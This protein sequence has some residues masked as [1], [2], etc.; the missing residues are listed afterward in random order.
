VRRAQASVA[1]AGAD[2]TLAD[3]AAA[4]AVDRDALHHAE[5][6]AVH[7]RRRHAAAEQ[8]LDSAPRR[9][10]RS[11]RRD[12]DIAQQQLDRA[13]DYLERTRQRTSPAVE[14]HTHAVA[15][16]RHAHDEFRNC[17]T[18][19]LLDSMAPSV[20]EQRLHVQAL[21]NWK[22]WAQ[23]HD[24]P[25]ASLH[26]TFAGLARQPGVQRHLAAALRNDLPAPP[27]DR[28][29]DVADRSGVHVTRHDFGIEL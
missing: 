9:Q 3:V 13:E 25:D 14:R 5:A 7:A 20:G 29:P 12:V 17:D 1:A 4:T 15:N 10:R 2:S 27:A 22:R 16:Q 8:R 21:T 23:G 19:D 18:V 26:T 24:L 11:L 28:A 6:R